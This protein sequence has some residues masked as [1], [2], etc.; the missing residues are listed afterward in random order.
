MSTVEIIG[1]RYKHTCTVRDIYIY[2]IILIAEVWNLKKCLLRAHVLFRP[3]LMEWDLES[4]EKQLAARSH[5]LLRRKFWR[6]IFLASECMCRISLQYRYIFR[7][8]SRFFSRHPN[9]GTCRQHLFDPNQSNTMILTPNRIE[10]NA[11]FSIRSPIAIIFTSS[12]ESKSGRHPPTNLG[13]NSDTFWSEKNG[14][15]SSNIFGANAHSYERADRGFFNWF[16][17]R[18][19]KDWPFLRVWIFSGGFKAQN[20]YVLSGA[21]YDRSSTF[22]L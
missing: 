7:G 9:T 18:L 14:V 8:V 4:V 20:E 21:S 19:H 15:V 13:E 12:C 17:T 5:E 6:L 2:R 22:P 3:L 10:R 16:R 11:C 1:G